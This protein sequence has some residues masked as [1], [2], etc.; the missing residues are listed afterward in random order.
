MNYAQAPQYATRSLSSWR[1]RLWSCA[2][3]SNIDSGRRAMTFDTRGGTATISSIPSLF[4]VLQCP[5]IGSV[6]CA[7][8]AARSSSSVQSLLSSA[9]APA[10]ARAQRTATM[11]SRQFIA[12]RFRVHV[13]SR[14]LRR[15][16]SL[17]EVLGKPQPIV[18]PV[19]FRPRLGRPCR[20]PAHD[21]PFHP[22]SR[23]GV[24]PVDRSE[25]CSADGGVGVGVASA[26]HRGDDP[27]LKCRGVQELVQGI[28]K[29]RQ[30]PPHLPAVLRW[31]ARLRL[32]D[33]F[34][35]CLVDI[36]LLCPSGHPVVHRRRGESF[37]DGLCD[38]G[39]VPG[40]RGAPRLH[41]RRPECRSPFGPSVSIPRHAK[42]P[43]PKFA[44][45]I[46]LGTFH[47]SCAR[48]RNF[49][50]VPWRRVAS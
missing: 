49:W 26:L 40:Q 36:P 38:G 6:R 11:L 28:L 10:A 35:D 32:L 33:A 4:S 2:S 9:H 50:P 13:F 29:R 21:D 5:S 15:C 7:R 31:P 24:A 27:F 47:G 23:H 42:A 48:Y 45:G 18:G 37:P 3:S 12:S 46:V 14:S 30:Y 22:L 8:A 44:P 39:R 43:K 19:F 17:K 20:G 41:P 25:Q 1:D 34:P 16:P